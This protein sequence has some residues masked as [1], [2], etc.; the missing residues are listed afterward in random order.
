MRDNDVFINAKW[1]LRTEA[2]LSVSS[3]QNALHKAR[4]E[5][6]IKPY[7]KITQDEFLSTFISHGIRKRNP[8]KEL[9][10]GYNKFLI[11]KGLEVCSLDID[12]YL[13]NT[14]ETNK[15]IN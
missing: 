8:K 2:Y 7:G 14:N 5:L 6:G 13:T 4:L 1:L 3:A 9:L 15:R 11:S 12:N 10:E